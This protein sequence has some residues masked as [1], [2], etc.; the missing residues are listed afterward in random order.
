MIKKIS[1]LEPYKG[2][3]E[4]FYNDKE[5]S[6][7]M[8]N[9]QEQIECNLYKSVE[10]ENNHILGVFSENNIIGLFVFLNLKEELYLE[11]IVGLSKDQFAYQ[12]ILYYLATNFPRYQCDFVFNPKNYLL[13]EELKKYPTIFEKEQLKLK[14]TNDV[15]YT[16]S[17]QVEAITPAYYEEYIQIHSKN[18]YWTGDKVLECSS[19]FRTWIV[20]ENDILAGY[21]DITHCFDENE[22]YDL[23]VLP[24][25]RGKGYGKSL[26][27][28]AIHENKPKK[29]MSLIDV[30]NEV[31]IHLYESLGFTAAAG[32]NII[33]AHTN[34]I[35]VKI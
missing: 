11:M 23:F 13:M 20:L 28:K 31:A 12:E 24:E 2:F 7:P 10:K 1:N 32:E 17:I 6:D 29:M 27:A 18:V 21:L 4:T 9:T 5:F 30:D 14:L 16:S 25:Y 8:L 26:L 33:T 34:F 19:K 35:G 3:I 15:S 22:P